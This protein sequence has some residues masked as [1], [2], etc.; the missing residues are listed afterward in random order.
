[1]LEHPEGGALQ[2]RA[3]EAWHRLYDLLLI[4]P[5]SL[6]V[7]AKPRLL[8]AVQ[9]TVDLFRLLETPETLTA[10][11]DLDV[12]AGAF[13]T[14]FTVP[15][16]ERWILT[17]LFRR[18]T[19]TATRTAIRDPSSAIH[20]HVLPEGTAEASEN[21]LRITLDR[22]WTI[23]MFSTDDALDGI[24]NLRAVITKLVMYRD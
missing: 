13:V 11:L 21:A 16:N 17:G 22:N 18:S 2:V 15:S 24:I 6:V 3:Y 12:S 23:G 4:E 7:A 19:N 9:P 1:V 8:T 20:Y 14:A 10:N 5:G